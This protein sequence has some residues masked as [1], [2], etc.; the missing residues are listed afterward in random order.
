M[1]EENFLTQALTDTVLTRRTFLKWSA[2]L[3]GTVALAGGVSYGLKAAEQAAA[4]AGESQWVAAS[5]WHNCGGRCLLKA[6]VM[7][8]TVLRVKTDDTHPDSADFP[9]QRACVRGRAQRMQILGADRL[10]Y[11]MKR[12]N[13]APGGGQKELR[14]RDEWVR[15]SWDEALDLVAE[16]IKRIVATH[17]PASILGEVNAGMERVFALYGGRA[18]SWG[19]TS[20]GT[21]PVVGPTVAGP[22]A[23]S[24]S[25]T[26]NDRMR[27]RQ[28]K[29]IIMWGANPAIS[30]NGNPTY[31]YLQAKKAGA[32]FIFVDPYYNESAQVLGDEWIPTRPGT[33]T[34]FLLGMAYHMIVNNLHDQA[35]LD[36]YTV[37]FDADHMPA[38]AD[39]TENFKDYVLGTY[40]GVPKT[41]E[42]ASAICG[43]PPEKIRALAT[44]YA[45]TQPTMVI[46]GGCTSRTNRGEQVAHAFLTLA[47]MTGN[48]GI[49]GAGT[50]LSVHNR[51][52]NAGPSLVS[53]GSTGLKSIENP[54]DVRLNQNEMWTA[55]LTGKYTAGKDD[56]RDVNIQLIYY[57]ARSSLN[58]K[59]GMTKGIEA[60][61]Q[62][63]FVVTQNFVLN[64]NAKYSDIVLPVTTQWEKF[65]GF[66]SGNREALFFD[67][68]V[69]DPLF[70]AR[71][72][73][74]VAKEIGKRLGLKV[75][76]IEPIPFKQQIFNQLAGAKV[77]TADGAG[78]EPLVTI[79]ADDIAEWGVEGE[80]QTGRIGVKEFK[81]KGL[82]QVPRTPGDNFGFTEFEDYVKDPAGAPRE[83][84][85]A[86]IEIHCQTLADK[87]EAYGWNS[88]SPIAAYD[89]PEEGY[90]DTFA[91]WPNRVKGDYPLQLYTIHYERRSHSI[92]DNV[93]W[94]REFFPQEFVMNPIDAAA[95]GLQ[96]GDIALISS[97][98]GKVIR[99]VFVTERMMPGVTTLGEGAWAEIDEESGIDKAGATNTLNGPI[100][101][102]QGHAGWNTCNVQV[103][104]YTGPI[105]LV[106]DAKWPQRIP[107][108]EA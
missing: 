9:Q 44:E 81:Q 38:G 91:D 106:R 30:S 22:Y 93:P 49:P 19:S 18:V 14:G 86:K 74:W 12:K 45:I 36:S 64:T 90:E 56:I 72:D 31:N 76:E 34:P 70:E 46:C 48:L 20:W 17:G 43:T 57:D 25:N 83:T 3:G 24:E 5:C 96:H 79:T 42:W 26:G 99:P 33:D 102:G 97:R 23:N 28:S 107:L 62:V 65:G 15:I 100:P 2:A 1:S 67:S 108:Q 51:A 4:A 7:D 61:R 54:V 80:P 85:S 98:H 6:E 95:R 105:K 52:G 92:F 39:P 59:M 58:Q 87:I 82:Y 55:I 88:K 50:G 104:P 103:E 40:D 63:E 13:W 77:V 37:G 10:K 68:L 21:W 53:A 101:T 71:D 35:F 94:L 78:Y 47:C 60:H 16:E 73:I 84:P 89:P 75:E 32:K 66:R 27:L 29:L 41:P 69:I 11:P 8:G